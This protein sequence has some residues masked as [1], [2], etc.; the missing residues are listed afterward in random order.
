MTEVRI[1]DD[2]LVVEIQGMDKFFTLK[3]HISIP[4]ENVVSAEI[5][6]KV[7]EEIVTATHAH[8]DGL[9]AVVNHGT[10]DPKSSTRFGTFHDTDGTVFYDVH[11][12]TKTIVINLTH[13]KYE[14][15][16]LEV[17]NPQAA[18][19]LINGAKKAA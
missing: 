11:D 4:L 17:E 9:D 16:V 14:R 1:E 3:S 5:D 12:A 15:L 6:L 13:D 10:N 8:H 7:G 19:A 2:Q 18:A